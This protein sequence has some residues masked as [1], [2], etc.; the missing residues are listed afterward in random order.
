MKREVRS[1]EREQQR[2]E[3]IVA[4]IAA[5]YERDRDAPRRGKRE[6]N[7]GRGSRQRVRREHQHPRGEPQR[8]DAAEPCAG[9][10]REAGPV[11][12]RGEQEPDDDGER[13]AE[14]HLVRMPHRSREIGRTK[15]SGE[16][17]RPQS[18]RQR[19]EQTGEQIE[20]S[21]AERE[22]RRAAR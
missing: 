5:L 18:D 14:Q 2:D 9:G 16:L 10:G 12:A 13:I 6:R 19:R 7:V 21:E 17:R 11:A 4:A 3:E 15:P 8:D 20:R 22:Q 1:A